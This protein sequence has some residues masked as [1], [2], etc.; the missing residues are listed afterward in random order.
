ME[1]KRSYMLLQCFL[2]GWT[3]AQWIMCLVCRLEGLCFGQQDP[4]KE[5]L[6]IAVSTRNSSI[7]GTEAGR[8]RVEGHS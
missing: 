4:H 7:R 3:V 8:L 5:K 1:L 6:G 2:E